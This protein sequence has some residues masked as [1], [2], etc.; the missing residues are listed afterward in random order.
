MVATV[1]VLW[2]PSFRLT[3]LYP[4]KRTIFSNWCLKKAAFTRR[5]QQTQV[6]PSLFYFS[7]YIGEIHPTMEKLELGERDL[8]VDFKSVFK[9]NL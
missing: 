3:K 4:E 7:V 2:F 9:V 8:E 5:S 1:T 6:I